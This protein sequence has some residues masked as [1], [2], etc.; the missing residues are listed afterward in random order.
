MKPSLHIVICAVYL[1]IW[2]WWTSQ[3]QNVSVSQVAKPNWQLKWPKLYE[4]Q[5]LKQGQNRAIHGWTQK[6]S[7]ILQ[8]PLKLSYAEL[9][10]ETSENFGAIPELTK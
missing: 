10:V 6:Y 5:A 3:H 4:N 8:I 7:E 2:L 9:G 1:W